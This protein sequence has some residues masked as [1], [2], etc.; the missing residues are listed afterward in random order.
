MN[1]NR[2][3]FVDS[4]PDSASGH[5]LVRGYDIL[6]DV[7]YDTANLTKRRERVLRFGMWVL[8]GIATGGISML[9]QDPTLGPH[10]LGSSPD[11]LPRLRTPPESP[12]STQ[13]P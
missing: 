5:R 6:P 2:V 13:T 8:G 3:E 11:E 7:T 9:F 4:H 1:S 10:E 12:D